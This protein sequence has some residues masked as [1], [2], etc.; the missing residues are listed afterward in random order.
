MKNS[1]VNP[2]HWNNICSRLA[3]WGQIM[4]NDLDNN[5]SILQ[6]AQ[7]QN[8]WFTLVESQRM[9]DII[10]SVY[11][12]YDS[13]YQWLNSY[14]P[15]TSYEKMN[16]ALICA[17]N[18]PMVSFHD[19]LC[20]LA[21]GY[22][23]QIKTSEKDNVLIPWA[24]N[25]W[26][27]INS[28]SD[29]SI[30]FTDKIASYDALI[31]TGSDLAQNYFKPY[32]LRCPGLIRSHRNGVGILHG[33]ETEDDLIALGHDVFDFYGL[34]CRNISK[35][36]VP[37]SYDFTRLLGIWDHHFSHV[38][39]HTKYRNNYEYNLALLIL[40]GSIF[41]QG[42]SV[43]IIQDRSLSSRIATLHYEY[44]SKIDEAES[45][46]H[47]NEDKIQCVV[48]TKPLVNT[49]SIF[50][51]RSQSPGLNDYADNVDTMEFLLSL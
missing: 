49:K 32:H 25:I 24:L 4:Q 50:P 42:D 35:L 29:Q 19:I 39:R 17:G 5:P 27:E 26:M 8:S 1:R 36:Y 9:I 33:D 48:S 14:E 31:A 51:G 6:Q 13:L 7:S 23:L 20:I 34:G 30:T 47:S 41:L 10:T 11:L 22:N 45:F 43:L 37:D 2:T 15:K 44:Y 28:A 18:I 3:H 46:V 21:C 16:I 40:N 12:N 38:I